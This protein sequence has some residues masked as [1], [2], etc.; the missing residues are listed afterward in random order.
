MQVRH[1]RA[2]GLGLAVP[3]SV[4]KLLHTVSSLSQNLEPSFVFGFWPL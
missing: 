3:T 1:T 2:W 4:S